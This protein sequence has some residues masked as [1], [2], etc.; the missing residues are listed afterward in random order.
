MC[1]V[2]DKEHTNVLHIVKMSN[3]LLKCTVHIELI[4]AKLYKNAKYCACVQKMID[5]EK[6]AYLVTRCSFANNFSQTSSVRAIS[7]VVRNFNWCLSN[8][9]TI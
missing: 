3:N 5:V 8:S 4:F 1:C 2:F 7:T 9:Q 6:D